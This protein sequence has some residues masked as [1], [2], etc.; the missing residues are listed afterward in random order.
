MMDLQARVH[1]SHANEL[2]Y[3]TLK[4]RWVHR[5]FGVGT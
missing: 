1:E 3:V 4:F 2:Q 5:W